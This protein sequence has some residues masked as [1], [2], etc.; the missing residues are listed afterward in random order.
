MSSNKD[1]SPVIQF[2][3]GRPLN[4]V[5]A[6]FLPWEVRAVQTFQP[7]PGRRKW[8]MARPLETSKWSLAPFLGSLKRQRENIHWGVNALFFRD[9]VSGGPPSESCSRAVLPEGCSGGTDVSTQSRT[10]DVGNGLTLG[11]VQ[12]VVDC[13]LKEELSLGDTLVTSR[14]TCVADVDSCYPCTGICAKFGRFSFP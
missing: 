9:S 1:Y 10:L 5:L 6:R 4:P 11:D 2:R 3:A 12:V 14:F 8:E 7:S 13:S